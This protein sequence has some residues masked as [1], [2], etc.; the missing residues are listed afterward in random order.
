[1]ETLKEKFENAINRYTLEA[2][3][4]FYR[5]ELGFAVNDCFEIAIQSQIEL[6]KEL[7]TEWL[8]DLTDMMSMPEIVEAK[9]KSLESQLNKE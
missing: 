2:G 3:E 1:M 9:I 7:H 4:L 6:L 8:N 5:R